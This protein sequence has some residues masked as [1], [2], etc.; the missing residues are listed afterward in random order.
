MVIDMREAI[1]TFPPALDVEG[2]CLDAL[3]L[4]LSQG[5]NPDQRAESHVGDTLG[6]SW[7]IC[8]L[9]GRSTAGFMVGLGVF[10]GV[11]IEP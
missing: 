3:A 6:H 8:G 5:Q 11:A 2:S 9:A 1:L 4:H 7:S 10:G